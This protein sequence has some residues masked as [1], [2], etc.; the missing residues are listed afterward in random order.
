[1]NYFLV[2]RIA[3]DLAYAA[4][5]KAMRRK[6]AKPPALSMWKFSL[7]CLLAFIIIMPLAIWGFGK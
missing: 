3:L 5:A 6:P 1:V 4:K 7:L 2:R